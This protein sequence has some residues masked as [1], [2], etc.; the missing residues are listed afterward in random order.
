MRKYY[1]ILILFLS[2]TSQ[3]LPQGW[4]QQNS[5]TTDDF[6][7]IFFTDSLNGWLGSNAGKTYRTTDGGETWNG[8]STNSNK[9]VVSIYFINPDTGWCVSSTYSSSGE[10]DI[11]KSTD[12]GVSWEEKFSFTTILESIFFISED[13]G[14]A[15]GTAYF[16]GG[17][18]LKSMDGGDT[19][20]VSYFFEHPIRPKDVY[21]LN[22]ST[23][24]I[25]GGE[26]PGRIFKTLSGG[27]SW[28]E[29]QIGGHFQDV[30]FSDNQ[31]GI[32]VGWGLSVKTDDGGETWEEFYSGDYVSKYGV[33]NYFPKFWI[34]EVTKVL[35]SS[36]NGEKWFPQYHSGGIVMRDIC[37]VNDS[38]GWI[39]GYDGLVLKT[40]NGGHPILG[41]PKIPVL[42]FPE[43]NSIQTIPVS[44]GWEE[45]EYSA[46]E[47]QVAADSLFIDPVIDIR[48][49][50]T[51][52]TTH[53]LNTHSKY[54]WRMRSET[55]NGYS[56]WSPAWFFFTGEI[57]NVNE[58]GV[59]YEFKL[60]QNYP[61]P[62]NPSTT[63][64]YQIPELSYVTLKVY[65]VLGNQVATIANGEKLAGSY[66]ASFNAK[67]LSSGI[68][69]YRLQAGSFVETKKM[70]LIK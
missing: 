23:G 35:N 4:F 42:L 49:I 32:S 63:I 8:F 59:L 24:F 45:L 40:I 48:Q 18:C 39:A 64:K 69:F 43:F 68:Y 20:V 21:F 34:V 38:I 13:I 51:Y 29:T 62:F 44:F 3:I 46:Y 12:G 31:H 25:V 17:Q 6:L 30:S 28:I 22:E 19:W 61:N 70:L 56:E 66:E 50:S 15:V 52:Y 14:W 16:I 10:G 54:Y 57:S 36:D 53:N 65:D 67:R 7:C 26:N 9:D 60:T 2:L 33:A 1:L 11:Y 27:F 47:L 55:I 58:S 41:E 5:N 37:F